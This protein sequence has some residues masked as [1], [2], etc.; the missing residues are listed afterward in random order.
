MYI[1][2]GDFMHGASNLFPAHVMAAFY[3]VVVVTFNYRLGA[4]GFL[5]TGDENSPGN[6]GIL[7][8]AMA[9]KWVYDN[10]E[11]FNG[12]RESITLFGPGA[13]AASAGL[14]MVAPQ[15]R[16]MVTRVI[17]QSG[18]ALADWAF[19]QD[20][21]RAQNTSRV[22]GL[23][24]GCSIESSWKLV[25][26]LRGRSP[27]ELG[28]AESFQHIGTFPWGPVMDV[29]FTYPGDDWY[30]GW[31]ESDWHFL[32][33]TPENLIRRGLFNRGLH[34]MSS[35]TT[36]EA[37]YVIANNASLAP[38]YEIDEQF[39]DQ[40]V[41]ELVLRYNYTLNPK[42]VYEAIRYMYTYWPD[43]NNKTLIRDQYIH[44]ISDFL[45]RAPVDK[46]VKLLLEKKVPVYMY[47][48]NTTVEA[49]KL[50]DW[51]KFQHNIEHYFLTGAPFM[52]VEFFPKVMRFERNGWTDNDR[53]MSHFFM[54]TYTNFARYG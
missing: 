23:L 28:N 37:A 39:F 7:D 11:F 6:Y 15:T 9:L 1:H 49:L 50:P 48:M 16:N 32:S 51:A 5:S 2:G 19:I 43:P 25:N 30:E 40:K 14:L 46:M 38:Y 4:L 27:Y 18:S 12:D 44:L 31:R 47:V 35:V 21:Y 3:Q 34:Y 53:N 42:G 13:G 24:L 17:A 41:R 22:M 52:D 33:E 54:K 8:Q 10:I 20:K 26:C 45:Y 36:Q 29:N